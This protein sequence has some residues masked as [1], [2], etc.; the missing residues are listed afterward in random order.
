M[1]GARPQPPSLVGRW[2]VGARPR[3]LP[4][5]VVPVLAGSA[6]AAG[7]GRFSLWRAALALF[8]ALALQVG[9]NYAN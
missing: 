5:A 8:V 7:Y 6:V 3:T 4:A 1:P 9:V 2:V